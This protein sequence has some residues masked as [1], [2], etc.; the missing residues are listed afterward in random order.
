MKNPRESVV[1]IDEQMIPFTGTS[2][3]KQYV[4]NKP[5]PVGLKN[6]VLAT[7]SRIVLDFVIYQ[8]Q[9]TFR[10]HVSNDKIGIGGVVVFHLRESLRKRTKIYCD[11]YFTSIPL[12]D[13][14]LQ[15]DVYVTGTLKKN[16]R[17]SASMAILNDKSLMRAGRGSESIVVRNNQ[18]V[19]IVK[20]YDNKPIL[21][22]SS[23]DGVEPQTIC[24]R[25]S[26]KE[27][28]YMQEPCPAIIREYN[29]YMGGVDL[30]DRMISYYCIKAR[31]KKWTIRT[32]MH[33]FD[34]ALANSWLQYRK[35]AQQ[36]G[37]AQKQIMQFLDF[38]MAVAESLISW[39]APISNTSDSD[40][41]SSKKRRVSLPSSPE[42][43]NG[44][45]HMP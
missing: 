24:R 36:L 17:S 12:I 32:I 35:E 37:I 45:K 10:P 9:N 33:L 28:M 41:H 23:C 18:R 38:C 13:I 29:R 6:F 4:P 21:M 39:E 3:L 43:R 25:W 7:P 15:S 30:V 8:G 27:K 5:N 22:A 2:L 20:W 16:R 31:T 11:C 14:M 44:A 42:R 19:T 1:C 34:L 40:E 26:K